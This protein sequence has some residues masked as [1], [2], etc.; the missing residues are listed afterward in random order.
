[1]QKAKSS[2]MKKNKKGRLVLLDIKLHLSGQC[3]TGAKTD[4]QT[5]GTQY[6][7]YK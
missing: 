5:T 3:D 4:T 1:M 6:K 2:L 7:I